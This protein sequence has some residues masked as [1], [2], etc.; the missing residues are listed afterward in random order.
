M[1][2]DLK[3]CVEILKE[4]DNFLVLSHEHPDGDT[5]G[6]AFALM[7]ALKKLGKKRA[8][9]CSDEMSKDFSYMYEG[10]ENDDIGENPFVVAVD[11]ADTHLLGDLA[12]KYGDKI[13]LCIDHHMSNAYFAEKLLLENRAAA[14]EI[15]FEVIKALG[16][17]IDEYIANCLYTGISTDTGCFRYQNT[18][19]KT[20][21]SVA[22]LV[23]IGVNTKMINKL[24]FETKT[25][26]FLELELL[27]RKT[28]EYH[29]DEK[30]AIITITQAMY[31]ESGSN[32]H[33]CYPITALPRQIEGVLVGAVIKEKQSG[34][35]GISVRTE[36]DI[37]ASEICARLGG[38]GHAGAAGCESKDDYETTKNKILE[39]IRLSLG[40]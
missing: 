29:F 23:E 15:V 17:E 14:C 30:C 10:I 2:I 36:G 25:K 38:G 11:V 21:R 39:S 7:S 34:A 8:F 26:S 6:S 31:E 4:N 16:V 19:S 9:M 12:E 35:Y 40:S 13:N 20:F 18:N 3:Q 32:E 22:D 24:M 33:E 27:A 28:L 37:D 5:L 1:V